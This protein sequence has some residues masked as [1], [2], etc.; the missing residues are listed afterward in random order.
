MLFTFAWREYQVRQAAIERLTFSQ[1]LLGMALAYHT[2]CELRGES[3]SELSDIE[4]MDYS[5]PRVRELIRSGEL[6][7][8]WNAMLF[9]SGAEN[10]KYILAYEV[11]A[12]S[13]G[14]WVVFAGGGRDLMTNVEFGS[15]PL[16]PVGNGKGDTAKD[17][18]SSSSP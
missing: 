15:Y 10:D 18:A 3:P 5:F 14:G 4:L 16:I 11:R 9:R 6:V 2:Y 7:V 17:K 13:E 8:R 12:P 1:E